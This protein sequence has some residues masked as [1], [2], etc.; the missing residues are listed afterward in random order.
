MLNFVNSPH[1]NNVKINIISY[2]RMILQNKAQKQLI[3]Y[4]TTQNQF[5]LVKY[6]LV[7]IQKTHEKPKDISQNKKK[8]YHRTNTLMRFILH[9][10]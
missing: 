4:H 3:H 6:R 9:L 10:Q 2:V 7:I 1:K 5:F 8:T